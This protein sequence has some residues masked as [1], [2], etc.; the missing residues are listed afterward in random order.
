M[1]KKIKTP[2]YNF[3]DGIK[4]HLE[5]PNISLYKMLEQSMINNQKHISYNYYGNKN[6]YNEFILQIDKCAKA[7]KSLGIKYKDKV[8]I[9]MPNTPEAII[10]FYALNKIG[11]I[12]NMIHPLSAENEIKNYLNISNSKYIITIDVS[13]NKINHI[14]KETSLKKCIVV[15]A[16]DSMPIHLKLGYELTKEER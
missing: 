6:T 8:S 14:A 3:Y 7:F 12:A 2:W 13:F 1:E 15:S 10:S 5:Y 16:K 9:C 4:E 11:A